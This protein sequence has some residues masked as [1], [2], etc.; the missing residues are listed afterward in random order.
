MT[1]T[2]ENN[3]RAACFIEGE[4]LQACGHRAGTRIRAHRARCR[5][6]TGYSRLG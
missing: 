4:V 5:N 1:V 6:T 2:E 3:Q